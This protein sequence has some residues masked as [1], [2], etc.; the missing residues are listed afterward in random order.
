[1][2]ALALVET[3]ATY[4]HALHHFMESS[5]KVKRVSKINSNKCW[6]DHGPYTKLA[7]IL[8]F[9]C[10]IQISPISLVLELKNQMDILP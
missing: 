9:F 5:V 8:I 7:Y 3:M 1:M 4:A 10:Y 6:V 2:G